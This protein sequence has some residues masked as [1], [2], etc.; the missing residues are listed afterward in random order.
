MSFGVG[1]GDAIQLA[2]LLQELI[3]SYTNA[4]REFLEVSNYVQSLLTVLEELSNSVEGIDLSP[5]L[6][7][8]LQTGTANSQ[9]LLKEL[10]ELLTKR[11]SLTSPKEHKLWDRLRWPSKQ[12]D[13]LR[14]RLNTQTSLLLLLHQSILRWHT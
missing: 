1:V 3:R 13:S 2:N 11:T 7:A 5:N 12:M 10:N 8:K 14:L 4:P 9:T 6:A